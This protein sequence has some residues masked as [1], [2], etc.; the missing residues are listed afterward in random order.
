MDNKW[1]ALN[2]YELGENL[3]LPTRKNSLTPGFWPMTT[4]LKRNALSIL[5]TVTLAVAGSAPSYATPSE[6][7][8]LSAMPREKVKL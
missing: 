8:V 2:S 4:G 1:S 5:D 6:Y 3:K 7:H